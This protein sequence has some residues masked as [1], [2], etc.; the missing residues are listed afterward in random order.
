MARHIQRI[1]TLF[2][3]FLLLFLVLPHSTYAPNGAVALAAPVE[4]IVIDGVVEV[5]EAAGA[6]VAGLSLVDGVVAAAAAGAVDEV[7]EFEHVVR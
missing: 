2:F 6:A 1:R 7:G 3:G 4:G 5:L